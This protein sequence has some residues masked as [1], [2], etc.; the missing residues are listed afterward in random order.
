MTA[1]TIVLPTTKDR[2]PV[3]DPVL[4]HVQ[5]QSVEDWELFIIGDGVNQ[6]TRE[7]IDRWCHDDP[8][9]R[10]FD[11]PKHPRRGEIYR[12]EALAQARGR[13]VAYLCDRD[14]WLYDHL[15]TLSAA[16]ENADF[17]HT[18]LLSID[19]GGGYHCAIDVDLAGKRRNEFKLRGFPIGMSTV[20]HRLSSYAR[21]PFGWR[22]TPAGSHTDHYMWA[23]FLDED[24]CTGRSVAWPTVLYF[25]RGDH[26]GWPSAQRA[27]ELSRWHAKVPD[28]ES[29]G[30]FRAAV[31]REFASP[32][33]RARRAWHTWLFWHPRVQRAYLR[34]RG[35]SP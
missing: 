11:H 26:P 34:L 24:W 30:S 35:T 3:L 15:E 19:P 29:Q 27:E 25:N 20:G 28:A 18:R 31:V 14:L 2:A 4:R 23:Q 22:T 10:F 17:A 13:N 8:R 32:S 5:L 33:N 1:F 21:L 7:V 9:I 16:L 12:H 6:E